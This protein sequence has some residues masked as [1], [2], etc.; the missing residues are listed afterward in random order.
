MSFPL[1]I[2]KK[3]KTNY[4]FFIKFIEDCIR[5]DIYQNIEQYINKIIENLI[6]IFNNSFLFYY[7]KEYIPFKI[8]TNNYQKFILNDAQ[9]INI[10]GIADIDKTKY[11]N[12]YYIFC[13]KFQMKFINFSFKLIY[14]L[15][16]TKIK[17][18]INI[19]KLIKIKINKDFPSTISNE[20]FES[21][22]NNNEFK[23]TIDFYFNIDV[24]S[25]LLFK[26]VHDK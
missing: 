1:L 13:D 24:I 4:E 15:N 2:K 19:S 23:N 9:F 3:N 12:Q 16:Q 14:D 17:Y 20:D 25:Y 26:S 7:F 5:E 10:S 8:F 6:F 18:N 22:N 21:I 11:L